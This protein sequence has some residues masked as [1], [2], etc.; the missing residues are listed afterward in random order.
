M[1]TRDFR[2]TKI[3]TTLGPA[4]DTYERIKGIF[5][6]GAS[7]AR[8]N[9]SHDTQEIQ[10]AK[11]D[12]VKRVEKELGRKIPVF[13]DLQGPKLRVGVF[14]EE[15]QTL[16]DG[17]FFVVDDDPAHGDSTRVQLPNLEILKALEV[18]HFILID[19][20]KIKLQ[21]VE[22]GKGYCKTKVVVG[23]RIKNRKGF[24]LPNT[25]IPLP[26]LTEKDLSDLEFAIKMG[27]DLVA[28]SFAQ[29]PG[30]LKK[31]RDTIKGR[32]PMITKVEKPTA[33]VDYIE[34]IID[35]SDVVMIAR[36]DMAVEVGSENV[37]AIQKNMI[38]LCREK[39]KPVIVATQM[40]ESM[41][42]GTFPTR[43]EVT[44]VSNAVY[45]CTDCCMLSAE[46]A[47]GKYPIEAVSMMDTI[48]RSTEADPNYHKY[49]KEF[50]LE[51][52]RSKFLGD[53]I[54]KATADIASDVGAAAVV[55]FT[56]S[57]STAI[58]ISKRRPAAPI[59]AMTPNDHV[60]GR[61]GF[62]WGVIP[63]I[64]GRHDAERL[65]EVAR[66]AVKKLGLAKPGDAI[67]LTFGK[68]T[69]NAKAMFADPAATIVSVIKV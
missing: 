42:E 60:A 37:P 10:K 24:N 12:I 2:F 40:L 30:D 16:E 61:V 28:V 9:F 8:L 22:K 7:I 69:A 50:T 55:A 66:A 14:K 51:L 65:D 41:I 17:Q 45:E 23:G 25:I 1:A 33:A 47:S 20:G 38:R 57:G 53:A 68:G 39:R 5:E 36:G 3:I 11:F 44:D 15:P 49:I 19:D 56:T 21:V 48:I 35:L 63:V 4:T 59:V 13:A 34:E 54:A 62:C 32:V 64:D 67:V 52:N 27:V 6:H 43:A 29:T 26:I 46:S 18:G 31:A 58:N